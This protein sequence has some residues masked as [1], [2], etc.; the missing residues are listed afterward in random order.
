MKPISKR[1]SLL[2]LVLAIVCRMARYALCYWCGY[3]QKSWAPI[4]WQEILALL[5]F[6]FFLVL[7]ILWL[8]SLFQRK[9]RAWTTAMLA[10]LLVLMAIKYV[11]PS[12]HDLI[13]KGMNDG[14]LRNYK[15]DD[16]RRF[17]HDFDQLPRLPDTLEIY[18]QFYWNE[19]L[20]KTNL[21]EKYPFLATCEACMKWDN[22]VHVDWGGFENHWGFTV[23]VDGKRI[24]PQH[25]EPDNKIIRVSD[26]IFFQSD[27]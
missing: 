14:M 7:L 21:K 5:G 16:M 13:L 20:N 9:Q 2:V 12:P 19:D 4:G 11:M 23:A 17:A 27:Y 18:K 3:Y 6:V 26:D 22:R 1:A 8:V 25:L 24:D 10:G 15:I